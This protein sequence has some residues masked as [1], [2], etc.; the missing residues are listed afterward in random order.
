MALATRGLVASR[1]QQDGPR[2]VSFSDTRLTSSRLYDS[3][4]ED[5]VERVREEGE[6]QALSEKFGEAAETKEEG[7]KRERTAAEEEKDIAQEL[8]EEQRKKSKKV[9]PQLLPENLTDS[10]GLIKLPIEMK[11]IKYKPQKGKKRDAVAGAA[12][13]HELVAAYRSF[14]NELMPTMNF[15]D[16]LLKIEQLGGKK[17][18]KVH[19]TNMRDNVQHCHLERLYGGEKAERMLKE[20]NDGMQQSQDEFNM[21]E[22][23]DDSSPVIKFIDDSLEV[24][25]PLSSDP[26]TTAAAQCKQYGTSSPTCDSLATR[27]FRTDLQTDS[28]YLR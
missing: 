2:R 28:M 16:V 12:Y 10:N 11:R 20:L 13:C 8:D 18:V 22:S 14:C 3:D 6:E 21:L 17:E 27:D 24:G 19:L 9:R 4:D 1:R 26:K 25:T 23:V 5:V 15:E 7:K